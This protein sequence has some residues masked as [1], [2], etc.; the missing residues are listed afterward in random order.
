MS[1]SRD[2]QRKS[3]RE[4]QREGQRFSRSPASPIAAVAALLAFVLPS[5]ALASST[6][7]AHFA[8]HL[9]NAH[10]MRG[11]ISIS[12]SRSISRGMAP[13]YSIRF[14]AAVAGAH[15]PPSH[16]LLSLPRG[17]PPLALCGDGSA[18]SAGSADH[19]GCAGW[20]VGG[21]EEGHGDLVGVLRR[22]REY[23]HDII[24]PRYPPQ[25][26]R[27]EV[28]LKGGMGEK[29]EMGEGL[30]GGMRGGAFMLGAFKDGRV[31]VN[32]DIR[33]IGPAQKPSAINLLVD[34]PE[35]S[36]L[37]ATSLQATSLQVASLQCDSWADA[38]F[39]MDVGKAS[40]SAEAGGSANAAGGAESASASKF[41]TSEFTCAGDAEGTTTY[42]NH[43]FP[44][45]EINGAVS[46]D[47]GAAVASC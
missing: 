31:V 42:W 23:S 46:C 13:A 43:D 6:G 44:G 27:L 37:Q 1:V 8:A 16:L 40:E 22:S 11:T 20:V 30:A 5:L 39:N 10:G 18:G 14:G 35:P 7:E 15:S 4:G 24:I 28:R 2:G 25:D 33:V 45:S 12:V 17:A 19:A 26:P 21:G 47:A 9:L 41:E 38:S 32:Y 34:Y 3:Q 29:A 36:S